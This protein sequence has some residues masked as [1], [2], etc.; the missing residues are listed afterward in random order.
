ML[1][2]FFTAEDLARVRVRSGADPLWEIAN[3]FQLLRKRVAGPVFGEWRRAVRSQLSPS[4]RLLTPLLPPTGYSPDFLTPDLGDAPAGGDDRIDLDSAID[5]VLRTPRARLAGDLRRLAGGREF[6]RWA[7]GLAHGELETVN[8][9]GTAMRAYHTEALA[10]FWHRIEAHVE[11]DRVIRT[12]S[13]LDG[14]TEGLLAGLEPGARWRPPVLEVAYPVSRVLR[15]EGRGLTLQPSFFCWQTPVMVA[16]PALPPVLVYPIQHSA[17]WWSDLPGIRPPGRRNPLT[18]LVGHTRAALLDA[19]YT[20][21]TTS[22]LADRLGVSNAA[23][24]QHVK[25]LREA[26]LLITVRQPGRSLHIATPD[27]RALLRVSAR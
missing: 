2:V 10:P 8:R 1:R 13:L 18:A 24:S 5:T 21:S 27:G 19:T 16:D 7:V 11:A 23:V 12:R 17:D 26:G 6:P 20:G 4:S 25:V 22:E 9:L 15:L 14:G 3:S